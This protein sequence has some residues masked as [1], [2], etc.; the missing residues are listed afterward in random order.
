MKKTT[1]L[2]LLL[3]TLTAAQGTVVRFETNFGNIDIEMKENEAPN[4]VANFLNYVNNGDY[5]N[6]IIHR[7]VPNFVI[8]G[9]E[10]ASDGNQLVEIP[11]N[12]PVANEFNLSNV[13]GTLAMAKLNNQPDSATNNFFFNVV[14]NAA[15]LDSQNGGFTVFGE[16]I[17]GMEV[18]DLIS[19]LQTVS[20]R[21]VFR[22]VP[23]SQV[24]LNN[25]IFIN[26]AF[27]L[28]EQFQVNAG[29]S[30]SWFSAATGGQGFYFEMLPL[31]DSMLV[32]WFTYE[33]FFPAD[34]VAVD[35][36]SAGHRWLTVEGTFG[37]DNVYTGTLILTQGG[38]FDSNE[39]VTVSAYGTVTIEFTD[40]E[41]AILTYTITD[42]GRTGT[43]PLQ[44]QTPVNV[45]LCERLASEANQGG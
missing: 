18:V 32:A 40:C 8:Q 2:L 30:G 7:S 20:S 28:S 41:T 23:G 3:L 25:N 11:E 45:A 43:I 21:P 24:Q 9:G 5:D 35:V 16:V 19:S 10:F 36:G 44:R 1:T 37:G 15:N 26:K 27:V 34:D 42:S 33:S 12:S 38:I 13:R 22:F 6:S 14:N 39:G 17:A 31:L 4:T 29:L